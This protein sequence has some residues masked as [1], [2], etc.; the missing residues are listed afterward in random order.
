MPRRSTLRRRQFPIRHRR[1]PGPFH[2][3]SL[4][5]NQ[6][7]RFFNG[8]H[9]ESVISM[10]ESDLR[11]PAEVKIMLLQSEVRTAAIIQLGRSVSVS[12]RLKVVKLVIENRHSL[13]FRPGWPLIAVNLDRH[14]R[15]AL[16]PVFERIDFDRCRGGVAME[17]N[18]RGAD[19]AVLVAR[20]V[21]D[22]KI[23]G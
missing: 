20:A 5:S 11:E 17:H 9:L 21:S 6:L 2:L 7:K 22:E 15:Q 12:V 10:P 19:I 4:A 23:E 14:V 8:L 13:L 18:R 3:P 16:D 1:R